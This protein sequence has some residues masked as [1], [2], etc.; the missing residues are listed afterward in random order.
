MGYVRGNRNTSQVEGSKWM[1]GGVVRY[2]H[3]KSREISTDMS[4]ILEKSRKNMYWPTVV[5]RIRLAFREEKMQRVCQEK[6]SKRIP[7]GI[8]TR[9]LARH[10][11]TSG[12]WTIA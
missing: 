12:N 7:G 1:V 5:I 11:A 2:I 6:P 8:F 10:H 9:G 4:K 3:Q